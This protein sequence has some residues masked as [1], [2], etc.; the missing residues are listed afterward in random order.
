MGTLTLTPAVVIGLFY[1]QRYRF[2]TIDQFV[3]GHAVLPLRPEPADPGVSS[4][5]M[6]QRIPYRIRG[7]KIPMGRVTSGWR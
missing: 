1:I 7:G 4:R 5:A 3:Q 2:L 6:G